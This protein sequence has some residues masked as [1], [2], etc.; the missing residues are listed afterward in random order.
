MGI[1]TLNGKLLT[2]NNKIIKNNVVL[3]NSGEVYTIPEE[4]TTIDFKYVG[5][6]GTTATIVLSGVS[7]L[8]YSNSGTSNS[9]LIWDYNGG[10]PYNFGSGM[11]GKIQRTVNGTV[12]TLTFNRGSMYLNIAKD[13][14]PPPTISPLFKLQI[15]ITGISESIM[16]PHLGFGYTYDYFINWGDGTDIVNVTTFNESGTTHTYSNTGNYIISI[17]GRCES[18]YINNNSNMK[19]IIT[20]VLSWGTVGLKTFSFYGCTN[21]IS[22]P[23]DTLGGLSN[24]GDTN[25]VFRNCSSLITIPKGIFDYCNNTTNIAVLFAGCSSLTSIPTGLFDYCTKITNVTNAFSGC[26]SLTSIPSGLFDYCTKITNFQVIFL[27]CSSL[28]SIPSGLFD[29]CT[30]VTS[31]SSTFSR[32]ESLTSIPND[33]FKYNTSV[34]SFG[35]MFNSCTSLTSI[36]NDLFKYNTNVTSFSLTFYNCTSLTSIPDNLFKYNTN[37]TSFSRTFSGCTELQINPYTFYSDGEQSTRFLNKSIDFTSCF[38]RTSF[39]GIQGTAP[40]LWN[41]NFGTGTPTR[42]DCFDGTGNNTTSI[43]NYNDIPIEWL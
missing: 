24:I 18:F 25:S 21:L 15:T 41:C 19:D 30:G 17:S 27:G 40:E 13:T 38:R 31:F 7:F 36:P 10:D 29:Y 39:T 2:L 14:T 35:S 20:K 34:T 3:F 11:T 32:C 6:T 5:E 42:T 9:E 43:S 28:T 22:V 1:F 33:L 16:I 26:S 37:V 12:F 23:S 4:T 8:I